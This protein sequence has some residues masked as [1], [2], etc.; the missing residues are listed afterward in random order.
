M[1]QHVFLHKDL[2]TRSATSVLLSKTS[3]NYPEWSI[4]MVNEIIP[5]GFASL[6]THDTSCMLH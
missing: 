4:K 1:F 6:N 5:S 2:H 3:T